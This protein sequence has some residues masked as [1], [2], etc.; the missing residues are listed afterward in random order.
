[1]ST[2]TSHAD[3]PACDFDRAALLRSYRRFRRDAMLPAAEA[4]RAAKIVRAF[5]AYESDG[6]CRIE[7]HEEQESYFDVYG[8]PDGYVGDCGRR[9]SAKEARAEIVRQIEQ[10]GCYCVVVKVRNPRTGDFEHLDSVGMCVGY[11]DPNSPYQNPY[12]IDLMAA[13]VEYLDR[14]FDGI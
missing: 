11:V 5:D 6:E 4:W 9:V 13:A 12:V 2:L 8:E 3:C 14:R 1:M 7:L 10:T